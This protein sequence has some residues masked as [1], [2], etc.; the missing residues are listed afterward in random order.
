[1]CP[2]SR[3][4][5]PK[6]YPARATTA[7]SYRHPGMIHDPRSE[8]PRPPEPARPHGDDEWFC[9][10]SYAGEAGPPCGWRGRTAEIACDPA[11]GVPRCPRCGR[12]T[13]MEI[14][15]PPDTRRA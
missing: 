5:I 12:A 8:M 2:R 7:V 6:H 10:H 14:A 3:R 11:G 1:M 4:I 9:I 13:L 15:P